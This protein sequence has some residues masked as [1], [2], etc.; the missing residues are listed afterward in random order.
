MNN[1]GEY[2]ESY[3]KTYPFFTK[4]T[5]NR[6]QTNFDL[7]NNGINGDMYEGDFKNDFSDGK[8]IY[9]SKNGDLYEGDFKKGKIEGKGII[10][11]SN[12]DREMGDYIDDKKIG[13][14]VKLQ[15]N[16]NVSTNHF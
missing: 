14:H 11:Y 16:G 7:N 6:L 12:G 8:G 3:G 15:I 9:Y 1:G 10:Y 4:E 13:T 5:F 2:L